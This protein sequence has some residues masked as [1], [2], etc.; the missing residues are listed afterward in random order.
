MTESIK[1]LIDAGKATLGIE[2]GSTRI[3]ATLIG[4]DLNQILATGTHD[5]EN[6]LGEGY[7]TY[8]VDSIWQGLAATIKDLQHNVEEQYGI[9]L[10]SLN[11]IGVSAMMHGYLAFDEKD[12]LLVPFRTWRNT[13]TSQAAK[14]LTDLFGVNIP[15]RW[16]V[17]H[18]QQAVLDKSEHVPHISFITT[19]AGYV[20]WMLTG[21]KVL[22]IGDA[23]GMFPID[24]A[25]K[26][27]DA[28]LLAA[29]DALE[30][31]R[32]LRGDLLSLLPEVSVAGESA[33][34]L[35]QA[36]AKLLDPSGS[37]KAGVLFCPPEGDAGSGMV[38]TNAVAPT[39][40]N[41]SAG[42]SIFAMVV[43]DRELTKVHHELDIVTTPV[44]DPVAMV[45]CN[46]GASEL[47]AWVGMFSRF[48]KVSGNPLSSDEVYELLFEEAL[49]GQKDAGGLLAYN[50]LAGE[51]IAG[52]SEGRPLFIRKPD[53]E[54]SLANA[55]LA[56]LY[57]VF[58]T[59]SLGMAVLVKENVQISKMSAHGGI[60][61]TKGVAQRI[62]SAA[63]SAP[64]SVSQSASEGGPWGMALLAA[65]SRSSATSLSEFLNTRVFGE[66][67]VVTILADPEEV[68]G[69]ERYLTDYRMG[70]PVMA[71]AIK[72]IQ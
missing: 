45:H 5:W 38:A 72:S 20:H 29:F 18:L 68:A 7:W 65:F 15:L 1:K 66:Q 4:E 2:L 24:S 42:T 61:R 63:I 17:A 43:M 57:G 39:T 6:Q 51:P 56:Q 53:S 34:S 46:N 64:V 25:N 10:Q 8:S 58:G 70:L 31:S 21:N 41:V 69:F 33:G 28:K 60:F 11:A 36:G 13:T 71:Q 55:I 62:L 47:A 37:L 12:Q 44:G 35:T 40:G 59:L 16:S 30:T 50:Y 52:L 67:E 27:Y 49:S 23:S 19:L 22:G 3:K 26:S 32:V 48:A 14:E 54:F 9:K